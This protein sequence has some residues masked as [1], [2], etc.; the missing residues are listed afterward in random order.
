MSTT[1]DRR[2]LEASIRAEAGRRGSAVYLVG[3]TVRDRLRRRSPRDLDVAVEGDAVAF[4]R[5]WAASV[6]AEAETAPAFGT[7]SVIVE[8]GA[9]PLRVD[10]SSTRGETYRHPGALPDVFPA[11]IEADL[12]RRD[13]TVN[14]MAIPLNGAAAGTL[15][16]PCGGRADLRRRVI[17]MLHSRSPH[18]DP[19]RAYR[20]VRFALRLGFRIEPGTRKWIASAVGAGVVARVSG[21]RLRRELLLLL[22]EVPPVSAVESL[23]RLGLDGAIEPALVRAPGRGRLAGLGR[24]P[25]PLRGERAAWAALLLWV[26]DA[27]AGAR[28]R[29]ADRLALS[30]ARRDEWARIPADRDAAREALAR[31]APR[32]D[33]AALSRRWSVEEL[34]AIAASMPA[35]SGRRLVEARRRADALRLT[36]GGEDLKRS[37]LP[38]GPGI[39][40][41]LDRTWRARIDGRIRKADELAFALVEGRR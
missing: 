13:F 26:L 15:I 20:A 24:A 22:G 34:S 33:L 30:G 37:G 19:T 38:P 40:K 35:A 39:G 12:L 29:V 17:R 9:R 25:V 4:A 28:A 27:P 3:G 1:D 32:S 23:A 6:G 41:A 36:I 10:F 7:A 5:G 18:D 14:A 2:R 21:D 8:A 31:G 16:D 11:G